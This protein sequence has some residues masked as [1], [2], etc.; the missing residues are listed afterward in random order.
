MSTLRGLI[1]LDVVGIFSGYDVSLIFK[2]LFAIGIA[3][4]GSGDFMQVEIVD[5]KIDEKNAVV[6]ANISF[7]GEAGYNAEEQ[8]SK[9]YMKKVDGEWFIIDK[10]K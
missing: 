9:F 3:A 6:E 1:I 5:V 4:A 8:L 10:T 7:P 2:D